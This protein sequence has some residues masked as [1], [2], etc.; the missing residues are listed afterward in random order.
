MINR[1]YI[2]GFNKLAKELKEEGFYTFYNFKNHRTEVATSASVS[3]V[4]KIAG[5]INNNLEFVRY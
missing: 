3:E 4:S 5:Y 2:K 1:E